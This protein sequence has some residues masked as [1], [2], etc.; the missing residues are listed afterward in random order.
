MK[1]MN[2]VF[3]LGSVSNKII[4]RYT[5]VSNIPVASFILAVNRNDNKNQNDYFNIVAWNKLAEKI[6]KSI[7][8][9]QKVALV[10]KLQTRILNNTDGTDKLI[11]EIVADEIF[12]IN[13][14]GHEP[15]GK[16]PVFSDTSNS[17]TDS[18]NFSPLRKEFMY[19][20]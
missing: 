3:L 2:K 19:E 18:S 11:V 9:G 14:N 13:E 7:V 20:N 17:S 12:C 1:T 8:A 4:L 6:D 16:F 5:K 15:S 10:G